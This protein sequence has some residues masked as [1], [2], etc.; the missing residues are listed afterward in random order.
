MGSVVR[1]CLART[2]CSG[3]RPLG[4]LGYCLYWGS[5]WRWREAAL[6]ELA[7]V[8]DCWVL[9][10]D[11]GA[12][13]LHHTELHGWSMTEDVL[14]ADHA[15]LSLDTVERRVTGNQDTSGIVMESQMEEG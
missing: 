3:V 4:T 11:L 6:E 13:Q 1:C 7:G 14:L 2:H 8:L 12:V 10:Q 9:G 15:V 5:L